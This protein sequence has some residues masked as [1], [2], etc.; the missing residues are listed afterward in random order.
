MAYQ[1]SGVCY[2]TKISAALAHASEVSPSSA[3]AFISVESVS[4]T[5][6]NYRASPIDGT[7][8]YVVSVPFQP[9]DC[10]LLGIGDGVI[11]GWAVASCW[12]AVYAVMYIARVVRG[13]TGENY[14]SA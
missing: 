2:P 5:L 11:M 10:Q 9:I 4:E 7:T 1:V 8:S 13:E 14:G 12:I 3:S 6:I